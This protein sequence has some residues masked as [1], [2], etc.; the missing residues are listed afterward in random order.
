MAAAD[1]I[2]RGEPGLVTRTS[3]PADRRATVTTTTAEGRR[4]AKRIRKAMADLEQRAL[5]SLPPNSVEAFRAEFDALTDEP[6]AAQ[7]R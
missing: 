4:V 3:R 6:P 5:A 1:L 2:V 7:R